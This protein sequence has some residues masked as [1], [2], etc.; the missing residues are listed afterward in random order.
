RLQR[1]RTLPDQPESVAPPEHGESPGSSRGVVRRRL[2]RAGRRRCTRRTGRGRVWPG[3]VRG[4]GGRMVERLTGWP[5]LRWVGLAIAFLALG[6]WLRGCWMPEPAVVYRDVVVPR[7]V[8][9]R[10]EPDTV[11]RWRERIVY[12]TVTAEQRASAPGAAASDVQAFCAAAGWIAPGAPA[13]PVPDADTLPGSAAVAAV[14]A[15]SSPSL[16]RPAAPLAFARS[17]RFDGRT[18]DLWAVTS[19]GDLRRE[20]FRVR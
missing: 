20:T 11:V 15:P 1:R 13:S 16:P 2:R 19:A 8:L 9:V 5:A 10:G 7:E 6:A 17:G 12:R 14:G 18:L 4:R 3:R